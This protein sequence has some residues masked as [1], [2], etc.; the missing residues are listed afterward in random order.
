LFLEH[1]SKPP[2]RSKKT[3]E[4]HERAVMHSNQ[5]IGKQL[6]SNLSADTI[7]GYLR[8]RLR[9]RVERRMLQGIVEHD[10]LKPSTVHQELRVLRRILNAAVR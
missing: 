1:D 4:S 7:E 10:V 9:A 5:A 2:L 3:H 8:A 6:L